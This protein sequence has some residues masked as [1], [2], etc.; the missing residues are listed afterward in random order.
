MRAYIYIYIY[1]RKH[2][3]IPGRGKEP[4]LKTPYSVGTRAT[5]PKAKV[6]GALS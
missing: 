1:M 5:F 4:F 6:A 2:G 3:S